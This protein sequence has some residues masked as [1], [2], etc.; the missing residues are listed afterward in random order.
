MV[1]TE[2]RR[3]GNAAGTTASIDRMAGEDDTGR[4]MFFLE[5]L[6]LETARRQLSTQEPP[7]VEA[8]DSMITEAISYISDAIGADAYTREI[9][10]LVARMPRQDATPARHA[11]Q[12][13][14]LVRMTASR[15]GHAFSPAMHA[16]LA[17][18]KE[19]R[20]TETVLQLAFAADTLAYLRGRGCSQADALRQLGVRYAPSTPMAKAINTYRQQAVRHAQVMN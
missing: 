2:Q 16:Y 10:T 20:Q 18:A 8:R 17:Q 6:V 4:D 11:R 9:A 19:P 7:A 5:S 15:H 1:T 3:A 14:N 12:V 13:I